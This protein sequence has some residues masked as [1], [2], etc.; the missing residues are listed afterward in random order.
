MLEEREAELAREAQQEL[1]RIERER[2]EA[3]QAARQAEAKLRADEA[4]KG[5]S[6]V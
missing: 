4:R 6:P 3:E 1:D 2:E 5:P